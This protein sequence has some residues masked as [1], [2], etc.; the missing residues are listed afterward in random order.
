[1]HLFFDESIK[2]YCL[3]SSTRD[4]GDELQLQLSSRVCAPRRYEHFTYKYEGGRNVPDD[5][6]YAVL[7]LFDA[8]DPAT[9]GR[10][11]ELFLEYSSS[12]ATESARQFPAP[13]GLEYSPYQ[14]AAIEYALPRQ[15]VLFGDEPGLGK[16]VEGL[17]LVNA[18]GADK[19]LVLCPAAVRLQW[20]KETHKWCPQFRFV[21]T[22]LK[23][24]DGFAPTAEVTICSYDLARTPI[25]HKLFSGVKWDIVILDE[26]H[27][28][29]N[30]EAKRTSAILGDY[31]G[32]TTAIIGQA[33]RVVA[34]TGTPLP[35]RPRECYTLAR[36]LDHSSISSMSWDAFL[37]RFNPA[38]EM[39]NGYRLELTGH[40]LELQARLRSHFMVRRAKSAV[41]KDLP[42]KQYEITLVEPTGEIRKVLKAEKLLDLDPDDPATFLDSEG[43]I[44]G[45]VSTVRREMGI[46]MIPRIVEHTKYVIE[47]GVEKVFLVLYHTEVINTVAEKLKSFKPVVIQGG[48]NHGARE[49]R[50]QTFISDPECRVFIGQITASGIGIDGLQQVCDRVVLGEP[51]WVHGNNEQAIDRLHRRGQKGSVLA[52]FLVAPDSLGEKI[53][54]NA[55]RKGRGVNKALDARF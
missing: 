53:V 42:E 1:V 22:I 23:S 46:A 24:K 52:Q 15:H 29:K 37:R 27:Y 30:H 25:F 12:F 36:A 16:T 55:I 50:K 11:V 39:P 8:A 6:P 44:D 4:K 33:N 21:H 3:H 18:A 20:A 7:P 49:I 17:G 45:A 47:S 13:E 31:A 10:L 2:A 14:R 51:D 40:L 34:M 54:G 28:L 48:V 26:A 32:N 9:A 43:K 19:V 38:A 5:N 41:L 35:N